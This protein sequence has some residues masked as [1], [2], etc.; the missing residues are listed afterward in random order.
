[1]ATTKITN[2]ESFDLGS[3]NTALKLPSGTT[4]ERPT[5]PSTGEWRYNTTTNLVE[6]YDG[7][8]W[9]ELSSEAIPPTPSEHFNTVLYDGTSATQSITG[10]GFQPDFVWIKRRDG[11]ENHYWQD[12]SRGST[13]QIYSNLTNA[14]FNETTAVTSFDSDGFTMGSYNGINNSGESYVAWCWKVNGG[15]TSSNTDGSISSTVQVNSKA[16]ISIVQYTGTQSN[17]T[18]GHGLGVAP[19]LV[20]TKALGAANGWPTLV[21]ADST[22]RYDGLRLNEANLNNSGNGAGF[23]QNTTPTDSVFYLGNS[24]ESNRNATATIA[25]CFAEVPGFSSIGGYSGNGS[26]DGPIINTGFEPAWLMIKVVTGSADGWFMVDNKRDTSNPRGIRVFANSDVGD[27]S[28]AGAQVDFFS[29]GFQLRGSGA[30]Q[31]QTNKSGSTYVYIAFASDPSTAPVLADS[32]NTTLYTGNGGTQS[33]TGLGFS[34]SFVWLKDRSAAY[35]HVLVDI[36]RGRSKSILSNSNSA[37]LTSN[38]GNDFVSFDSDGFTVGPLQQV[39]TNVNADNFVSWNWKANPIPTI[40]T[41]GSVTAFVS[42]NQ[43]SG[44]SI[45]K[46]DGTGGVNTVGHGLN[47]APELILIKGVSSSGDWQVYSSVSGNGN[48][49]ILNSTAAQSSTTRFDSTSPTS[50]VFTLND[51]GLGTNLVAY[52]FYSVSGFSKIGSYTGD[53]NSTGST[54]TTSFAPSW[55]LIKRTDSTGDWRVWDTTRDTG[56]PNDDVLKPNTSDAESVNDP[57]AR[58]NFLSTGFQPASSHS[59]VNA[60]GANYLYLAFKANPSPIV[61]AG[62]MAFLVVAGGGSGG[63]ENSRSGGGGGA[64]GLRTSFGTT[65]GGGASAES[66]ITLYAGTYTITIGSGGAGQSSTP[67]AG[68]DGSLSS[69]AASSMTTI[70]SVGGGG[71]GAPGT[72]RTGGSGGGGAHGGNAGGSGT[73]NQGFDGGSGNGESPYNGAGG[74]GASAVGANSS[75][76][77]GSGNGGNGLSVSITGSATAYAGGGGGGGGTAGNGGT[78]G[79]GAGS[80]STAGGATVNTGGG[81]GGARTGSGTGGSGIVVLRLQTAEYSGT[82]TGSPTVTTV[83][84]E[85]ILTYTGSGTYVHS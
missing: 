10:V 71:G 75:A 67:S 28:E 59:S 38:A 29:N 4:A 57:S 79:G 52:A 39:Y 51:S 19:S 42:A 80:T 18:V 64:G 81:G 83:G 63:N 41:D 84:D 55:I 21:Q 1:M 62:Q 37:N 6:Y 77:G 13:Q 68:N 73:A 11:A 60:S 24:D 72:G 16:G 70:S 22:T 54:I 8:S 2:P 58:I 45:I 5:S 82:T 50:S 47:S 85:T 17:A 49:L 66:N 20:I 12:S 48:K 35:S 43:A 34:P 33:I 76:G 32:F 78:G 23:F 44:F 65:S 31:G 74:G 46:W 53:G 15:T 14:Q 56:T 36:L 40:N 26:D 30:G 3:L 25:Y 61:P 7:G 9:R 69:I 27:A